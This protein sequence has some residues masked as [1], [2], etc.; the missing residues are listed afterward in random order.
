MDRRFGGLFLRVATLTGPESRGSS[1]VRNPRHSQTRQSPAVDGLYPCG[2]G[3]GYAGGIISAPSTGSARHACLW[4]LRG[5]G[6]KGQTRQSFPL[7]PAVRGGPSS[8]GSLFDQAIL[9]QTP[10]VTR[11][12]SSSSPAICR[13]QPSGG[14][15]RQL[16]PRQQIGAIG[17]MLGNDLLGRLARRVRY[18]VIV[19][20]K[21]SMT[22]I[23]RPP[24]AP[25]IPALLLVVAEPVP[26]APRDELDGDRG[27]V[28][29]VGL[30][31]QPRP[32]YAV[33]P[34]AVVT[35]LDLML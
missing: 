29:Y 3:A 10:A 34:A 25:G 12:F 14:P 15:Q 35:R 7:P 20:R 8:G 23:I 5:P 6:V 16:E 27:D 28:A 17:F 30:T 2:E 13:P 19:R 22:Q 4:Q 32:D 9:R 31:S 33:R 1:P 11:A 21:R 26:L 18:T 24:R